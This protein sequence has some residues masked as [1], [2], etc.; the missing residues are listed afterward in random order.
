MPGDNIQPM[1]K[2]AWVTFILLTVAGGC[3]PFKAPHLPKVVHTPDAVITAVRLVDAGDRA[4]RFDVDV[5]LS[6]PN[7]FPLPL[8][9]AKYELKIAGLAYATDV[10]PKTTLPAAGEITVTLP[11]VLRGD[12]PPTNGQYQATG[13][14][15]LTPGGQVRRLFYDIGFPKPKARF[16][17][18]GVV[19]N[20]P[21]ADKESLK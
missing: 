9:H 11:A 17:G 21:V 3:G 2:R 19:S 20:Q 1:N 4:A 10:L 6:N 7:D 15:E 18:E 14:I 8:T 16:T 13:R 12:A 5:T